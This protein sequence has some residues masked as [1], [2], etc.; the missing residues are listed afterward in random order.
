[1]L[2]LQG[3]KECNTV[4]IPGL[5]DCHWQV[6]INKEYI[7]PLLPISSLPDLHAVMTIHLQETFGQ[8]LNKMLFQPIGN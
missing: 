1:M 7:F 5:S 8:F 6:E 4:Y 3:N 2:S